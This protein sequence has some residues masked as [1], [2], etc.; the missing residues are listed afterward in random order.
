M[1]PK[2]IENTNIL[3]QS[4]YKTALPIV[5]ILWLLP[6]IAVAL[7][8]VRSGGDLISGNYWGWPTSFDLYENYTSVFKNTPLLNTCGIVSE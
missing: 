2:P 1:F 4:V 7:T 3:T 6:L 8:S 5:L